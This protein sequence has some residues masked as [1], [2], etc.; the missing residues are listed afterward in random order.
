MSVHI[1]QSLA[2]CSLGIT[3]MCPTQSTG[4]MEGRRQSEH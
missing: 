4:G 3:F 1:S 2:C